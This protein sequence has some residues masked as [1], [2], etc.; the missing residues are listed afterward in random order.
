MFYK[1]LETKMEDAY[2]YA[3]DI[4][5][6]NMMAEDVS[7]GVDAFINKRQAV[8]KGRWNKKDDT[9]RQLDEA[10][11][12]AYGFPADLPDDDIIAKLLEMYL[13]LLFQTCRSI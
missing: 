5:A 13:G 12:A 4:M 3:G 7:E 10:V 8:W 1:Q 6:C 11:A 9:H 2:A